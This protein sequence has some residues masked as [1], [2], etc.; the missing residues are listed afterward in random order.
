MLTLVH[1]LVLCLCCLIYAVVNCFLFNELFSICPVISRVVLSFFFCVVV[2]KSSILGRFFQFKDGFDFLVR[3]ELFAFWLLGQMLCQMF[4]VLEAA[5]TGGRLD[6]SFGFFVVVIESLIL[7][8]SFHFS[9]DFDIFLRIEQ[10]AV[11]ILI[12]MFCQAFKVV[13]A[14]LAGG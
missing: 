7:D 3:V 12:Q 13:V 9:D 5:L 4:K 10:F 1:F 11:G 14:V 8:R 2:I 6:L